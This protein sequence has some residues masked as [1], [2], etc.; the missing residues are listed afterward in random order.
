MIPT[1]KRIFLIPVFAAALFAWGC[2]SARQNQPTPV[3]GTELEGSWS[4]RDVTPGSEGQA[5]LTV[6][7]NSIEFHGASADDWLKGTFTLKVDANPRQFVG[8]I[9][10][11]ASTDY[12]GKATYAIYKLEGQT[13]TISGNEP[14]VSNFPATLDAQGARQFVFKRDQ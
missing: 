5:T 11:C 10:E 7:N 13:L 12:V 4:G 14:G 3:H 9:T 1:M 2:S 6:S 8:S